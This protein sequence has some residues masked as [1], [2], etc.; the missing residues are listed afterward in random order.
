VDLK[1]HSV[2]NFWSV[3]K[4][5]C[6]EKKMMTPNWSNIKTSINKTF[7]ELSKEVNYQIRQEIKR[8]YPA[9]PKDEKT[10]GVIDYQNSSTRSKN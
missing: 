6:Q 9:N 4:D 2:F 7:K 8:P 1:S 10:Q 5:I 3:K